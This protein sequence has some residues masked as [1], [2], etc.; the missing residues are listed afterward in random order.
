MERANAVLPKL[1]ELLAASEVLSDHGCNYSCDQRHAIPYGQIKRMS[2]Q[3][4]AKK[5]TSLLS[6]LE[7]SSWGK[8]QSS[9]DAVAVPLVLSPCS[10]EGHGYLLSSVRLWAEQSKLICPRLPVLEISLGTFASFALA[11]S[12]KTPVKSSWEYFL[13]KAPGTGSPWF[14]WLWCEEGTGTE[15]HTCKGIYCTLG[16]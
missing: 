15:A 4:S 1:P 7:R 6:N 16:N 3:T 12:G 2:V 13:W 14:E 11:R 8:Y 10:L 5:L 9:W